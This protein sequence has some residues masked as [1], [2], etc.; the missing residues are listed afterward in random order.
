MEPINPAR[1]RKALQLVEEAK[2]ELERALQDAERPR[3]NPPPGPVR[4]MPKRSGAKPRI[5]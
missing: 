5:R 4:V 1:I 2:D 3:P